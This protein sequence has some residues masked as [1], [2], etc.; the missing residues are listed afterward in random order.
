M[1][2]LRVTKALKIFKY[3]DLIWNLIGYLKIQPVTQKMIL[4]IIAAFTLVHI[5]ACLFYMSAR[6][7]DFS[8][9]TWVNQ[10]GLLD[11]DYLQSWVMTMYWAF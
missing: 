6:I 2:I 1:R 9:D 8:S 5:F 7:A 11:I 3:S 4:I 10:K